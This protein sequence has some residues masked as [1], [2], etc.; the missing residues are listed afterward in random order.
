MYFVFCNE[1]EC[2]NMSL[3][4]HLNVFFQQIGIFIEHY[5]NSTFHN[6]DNASNTK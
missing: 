4:S 3:D 2:K 5:Q 1:I 6:K